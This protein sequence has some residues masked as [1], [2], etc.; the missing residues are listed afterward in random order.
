MS[1]SFFQNGSR[2]QSGLVHVNSLESIVLKSCFWLQ[3]WVVLFFIGIAVLLSVDS[4]DV[5]Y[6]IV[7]LDINVAY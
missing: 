3:H 7:E 4:A 5:D 1:F 6:L 2:V